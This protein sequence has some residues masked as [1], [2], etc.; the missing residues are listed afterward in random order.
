MITSK[1]FDPRDYKQ[2]PYGEIKDYFEA[3]WEILRQEEI[4]FTYSSLNRAWEY[5]QIFTSIPGWGGSKVLDLGT[6]V[7]LAP[8]YMVRKL[9]ASVVTFDKDWMKERAILYSETVEESIRPIVEM[10]DMTEPLHYPSELFD[11]VTCFSVIEHLP[12]YSVAL[13]EMKRVCKKGGYI[14]ITTDFS[15]D[16]TDAVK[17]GITFNR[18]SLEKLIRTMKLPFVGEQN[19]NNVDLKRKENL[20]VNGQYTFLS[21]VFQNI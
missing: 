12:D 20:A 14:G 19:F 8:V 10:G 18:D 3:W 4:K 2:Y 13:S 9:G 6:S 16:G 11:I 21:L 5:G 7:S 1:L 15:P 17:S